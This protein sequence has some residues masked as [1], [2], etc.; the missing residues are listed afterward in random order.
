MSE[1]ADW[2]SS[3]RELTEVGI[4]SGLRMISKRP[5]WMPALIGLT[6]AAIGTADGAEPDRK[7]IEFFEQRIRPVFVERC[8]KCHSSKSKALKGGL[9]LDS[10][11]GTRKGG[12]SG[13]AVVPGNIKKSLLIDAISY[14]GEFYDM[15]PDGK[16]PEQ[17]IADFRRW[18]EMGAPDP[19]RGKLPATASKQT[20]DLPVNSD[21]W[22]FRPPRQHS[23]PH[24]QN[25]AWPHHD[26]DRFVLAKLEQAG[27]QPTG[28]ANR[29]TLLRRVTFDLTGLPPTPAE[30]QAF[31]DD[32]SAEAFEKVVDRLL[33]SPAFGDHWAR[34]WF[35]LSCYADLADADGNV[36]IR[37]A[38]RYRDYVI[39]A[40]NRD[41]PLNQFI[42]EQIAGDLL[43]FDSAQQRREQIIATGFLA[44]GPWVLQNYIKGQMLADEVDHQ[45]DKIGRVF[46]GMSVGC[47]RCHDHKFDPI[48]TRDYY[49][50]AGIFHST[51]TTRHDGP[52]VWSQIVKSRLPELPEEA[53]EREQATTKY[54]ETIQEI[55]QRQQELENAEQRLQS[56]R[57]ALESKQQTQEDH[58]VDQSSLQSTTDVVAERK[59][60]DASLTEV[61]N[62]LDQLA[63]RLKFIEYS[64]PRP[65]EALAVRDVASPTDSPIYI[66]GNFR[67]L[68][69][70][71]PRGFLTAFST[72]PGPTIPPGASGRR[73]L[74]E[75]L[76][77]PDNPLTARVLVN[78]IWYH[79]FGHGLVRPVDYFGTQG[80]APSHPELLD[81]LA[82]R[83]VQE[84][85]SLKSMVR[86]LLLSRVYQMAGD[87]NPQ[88]WNI[89]PHNRLLWRMNRRRL[90]AEAIRDA[91]LAVSGQ[92]NASRGGPSLG[93]DIPNNVS[94]IGGNANPPTYTAAKV[95]DHVANRRTVYLPLMRRRPSKSLEIL[96]V[97]DFPHPNDI[98]GA[99]NQT[100]V[101]TQAL[102]LMNAPFVKEQARRTAERLCAERNIDETQRLTRL[103]LLALN[104]PLDDVQ[105]QQALTFLEEYKRACASLRNPPSQP[106]LEAWTQYCHALFA[107]NEF[108]FRE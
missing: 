33:K 60:L 59:R 55:K 97:F 51:L 85:W 80:K 78:R 66:R 11:V 23:A 14:T 12:Q 34:H 31:L 62:E 68:G 83:L 103:H 104:R 18:I 81:Y 79:L 99:R 74:A 13:A 73:E 28:D 86:Q 108:L 10:S 15:P 70:P 75:W 47:A 24:V 58:S 39:S 46:L 92:L 29:Y 91:M 67:T 5:V 8:Y 100:T 65:P 93:L 72:K 71:V 84:D 95:P 82:V 42:R 2:T 6:L 57:A 40:F 26:L 22:S 35:D 54:Q 56:Q 50:L 98:T 3:I 64:R 106:G 4:D 69:E 38:W 52:G 41:K 49:A 17:I 89:D 44:I 20:G 90:P 25:K 30:I 105:L 101:P 77:N 48:P 16:L 21:F 1:S 96:S 36:I 32:T 53:T 102:F 63:E 45:I 7:G 76:I 94:G 27:L 9:R 88:A 87:H 43:P 61:K 107:S 37:D 19:R